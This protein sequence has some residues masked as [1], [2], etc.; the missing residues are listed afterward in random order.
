M[1]IDPG[2]STGIAVLIVNPDNWQWMTFQCN[3]G[4]AFWLVQE[5]YTCYCPR[6]VGIE[7][8]IPMNKG[9]TSGKDA[10]LTRRVADHAYELA[11]TIRR[12]EGGWTGRYLRK[13][14]D[15]KT[16]ASDKRLDKT[17]FPLGKKFLD[18][19][20]AGRHAMFAAVRDGRERDPLA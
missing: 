14:A 10:E 19:R 18:A 5:L 7:Q 15:V 4:S 16:W 9:G 12:P 1:G 6:A 3:G 20:D 11:L 17:G 8:F 13:A 2:P